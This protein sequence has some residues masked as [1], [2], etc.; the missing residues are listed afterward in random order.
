MTIRMVRPLDPEA[1]V[2][3]QQVI[4]HAR[5]AGGNI[6]TWLNSAG[7]LWTKEKEAKLKKEVLSKLLQD[8][9]SW[10]PHEYLRTVNKEL[11]NCTPVDMYR[12]MIGFIE[13]Y[14][15]ASK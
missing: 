6:P 11:V 15:D 2:Q 4:E 3:V 13:Q 9:K 5:Y 10:L 14:L 7:L 1:Q 8:M 12:A